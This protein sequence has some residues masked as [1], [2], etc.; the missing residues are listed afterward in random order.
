MSSNVRKYK[1]R[2]D[3][4]DGIT[5][6][7][8]IYCKYEHVCDVQEWCNEDGSSVDFDC[9]TDSQAY[10]T[11]CCIAGIEVIDKYH[12]WEEILEFDIPE[13]VAKVFNYKYPQKIT[14]Y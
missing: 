1:I 8:H 6:S 14:Q 4:N 5:Y 2:Y 3:G 12:Y 7:N 11:A 13:I 9:V 10:I